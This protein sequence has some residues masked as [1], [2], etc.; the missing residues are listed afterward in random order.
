MTPTAADIDDE[1][2]LRAI[3]REVR[4]IRESLHT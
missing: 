3:L 4:A 1:A 2:L